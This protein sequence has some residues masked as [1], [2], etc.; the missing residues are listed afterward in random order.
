MGSHGR[1][2]TPGG[3]RWLRSESRYVGGQRP[4]DA[5]RVGEFDRV[6][7]ALEALDS[8]IFV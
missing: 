4:I 6:E 2:A 5:L 8:G 7:A 1:G 3:T